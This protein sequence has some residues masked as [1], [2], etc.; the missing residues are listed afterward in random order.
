MYN[1]MT[2]FDINNCFNRY[3]QVISFMTHLVPTNLYIKSRN[4]KVELG[5]MR[6]YARSFDTSYLYVKIAIWPFKGKSIR[7]YK[8]LS[9]TFLYLVQIIKGVN[10]VAWLIFWYELECRYLLGIKK[11]FGLEL[12]FNSYRQSKKYCYCCYI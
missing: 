4:I 10:G 9:V 3:I 1:C 6:D 12:Q 11:N 7:S 8:F 5:V 2:I